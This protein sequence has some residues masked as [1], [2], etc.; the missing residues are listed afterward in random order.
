[1]TDPAPHFIPYP[2]STARH[3]LVNRQPSTVNHRL[4]TMDHR[5]STL[6]R[7]P[8]TVNDLGNVRRMYLRSLSMEHFKIFYGRQE[9]RLGGAKRPNPANCGDRPNI[10]TIIEG[11]NGF[12]KTTLLDALSFVLYGRLW[13]RNA[14]TGDQYQY[15]RAVINR[16]ALNEGERH[17][18][19][20][21]VFEHE[22][23]ECAL[24]RRL[25]V[26]LDL[27][28]D[29]D[30]D[31][32]PDGATETQRAWL[33]GSPVVGEDDPIGAVIEHR[34]PAAVAGCYLFDGET[35]GFS[36]IRDRETVDQ[37][38]GL[39]LV[40][41]AVDDLDRIV[42]GYR[43]RLAHLE[44]GAE[45]EHILARIQKHKHKLSS[46]T[47]RMREMTAQL[48][49]T[50]K[51]LNEA[52]RDRAHLHRLRSLNAVAERLERANRK[53]ASRKRQLAKR[54]RRYLEQYP[55]QLLRSALL[56]GAATLK[57]RR[58]Q[59]VE[60]RLKQGRLQAQEDLLRAIL[61]AKSCICGSPL[62]QSHYGRVKILD[63]LHDLEAEE[64]ALE[65]AHT[66]SFAGGEGEVANALEALPDRA[67]LEEQRER[68]A[69]LSQRLATHRSTLRAREKKLETQRASVRRALHANGVLEPAVGDD[70]TDLDLTPQLEAA[71]QR[72]DALVRAGEV[73]KERADT[74]A[75]EQYAAERYIARLEEERSDAEM[76]HRDATASLRRTIQRAV[77]ARHACER[78]MDRALEAHRRQVEQTASA[79]FAQL[80]NKPDQ[81][82]HITLDWERG[83]FS[84]DGREGTSIDGETLSAGERHIIKIAVLGALKRS[85]APGLLVIDNPFGRLDMVHRNKLIKNI[86]ALAPQVILLVKHPELTPPLRHAAGKEPRALRWRL[87]H[88]PR[89][90]S[91]RIVPVRSKK[92]ERGEPR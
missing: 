23:R 88:E 43:Q 35:G 12:G 16:H 53:L 13:C 36:Y 56:D 47:E 20:R 64:R 87:V 25:E 26:E 40:Q 32:H 83:G 86:G 28:L 55:Y 66:P 21:V 14:A 85:T 89:T 17:C 82:G 15:A 59:K 2:S 48:K 3:R 52:K 63:L 61:D 30:L 72:V 9:L 46:I 84:I 90:Q 91:S 10:L 58:D 50:E 71:N 42:Y 80:T 76:R 33:D 68:I 77:A 24:E 29:L 79:L 92:Q 34:L 39:P 57:R 70:A 18:W 69:E 31:A 67:Y 8:S 60:R 11:K 78:T 38:L 19:V 1:M 6:H 75:R 49:R 62:S 4:W 74:L 22:G 5:S 45:V 51:R 81:F 73:R 65:R 27:D 44:S 41:R 54:Q 37:L 7:Q